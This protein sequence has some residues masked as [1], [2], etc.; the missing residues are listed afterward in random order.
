[1]VQSIE[2]G[3]ARFI[4]LDDALKVLRDDPRPDFAAKLRPRQRGWYRA[5][6]RGGAHLHRPLHL[7]DDRQ[8]H[9]GVT[10]AQ[11]SEDEAGGGGGRHPAG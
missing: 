10:V 9:C 6:E 3:E 5:A 11:R 1:M 2:Q 4:H 8:E 7:C